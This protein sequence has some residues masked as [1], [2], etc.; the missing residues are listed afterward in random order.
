MNPM[1]QFNKMD[2]ILQFAE[3][4]G[5]ELSNSQIALCGRSSDACLGCIS[6]TVP[7]QQHDG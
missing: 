1:H 4:S 3:D 7:A 6:V 2:T 5:R